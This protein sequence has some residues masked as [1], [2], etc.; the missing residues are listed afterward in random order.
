MSNSV[1][2]AVLEGVAFCDNISGVYFRVVSVIQDENG[3]S[4]VILEPDT[5]RGKA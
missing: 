3:Q 2:E 4:T 5:G 1:L